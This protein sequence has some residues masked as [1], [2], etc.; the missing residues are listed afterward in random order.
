M[1]DD[2]KRVADL[3]SKAAEISRW[4]YALDGKI[5]NF[6]GK[7]RWSAVLGNIEAAQKRIAA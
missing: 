1:T 4:N 7:D 6:D 2:M 3:L 5:G